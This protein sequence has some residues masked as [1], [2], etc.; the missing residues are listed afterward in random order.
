MPGFARYRH[1]AVSDDTIESREQLGN[2]IHMPVRSGAQDWRGPGG[3]LCIGGPYH[4]R[5]DGVVIQVQR[6]GLPPI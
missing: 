4:R 6:E 3:Y 5:G 2:D 1:G